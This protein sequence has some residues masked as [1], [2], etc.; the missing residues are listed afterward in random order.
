M[1]EFISKLRGVFLF[2]HFIYGIAIAFMIHFSGSC[3]KNKLT[4][5]GTQE[6]ITEQ[7][8]ASTITGA[9]KSVEIAFKSGEVANIQKILTPDALK[10]YGNDLSKVRKNDFI[11][12]AQA[13]KTG[14][15]KVSTEIYAEYNYTKDKITY[16]IAMA[17]Q[18]DGLW[19]LIRF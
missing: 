10:L 11:N 13:L 18:D 1:R 9:L 16:S 12:L 7:V 5:E 19:K 14:Q 3:A 8:D 17:K 4:D 2:R 6:P 15:L